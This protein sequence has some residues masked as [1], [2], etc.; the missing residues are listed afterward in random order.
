M[1]LCKRKRGV[2][3]KSDEFKVKAFTLQIKQIWEDDELTPQDRVELTAIYLEKF[4]K[5][6]LLRKE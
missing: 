2:L 3:M 6:T 1:E 4:E 5:E